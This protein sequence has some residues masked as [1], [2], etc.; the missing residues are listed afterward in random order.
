MLATHLPPRQVMAGAWLAFLVQT[1]VAVLA[2]S[3]LQL[4]PVEPVRLRLESASWYLH[5]HPV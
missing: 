1:V 5:W 2:G 4:F 3:L